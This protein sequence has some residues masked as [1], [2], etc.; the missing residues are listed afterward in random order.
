[1]KSSALVT[2]HDQ[3]S[4]LICM[5]TRVKALFDGVT[6]ILEKENN[7]H[8][9]GI[10]CKSLSDHCIIHGLNGFSVDLWFDK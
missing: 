3:A 10:G 9:A 7:I 5:P 1:M 4:I 6:Y 2:T 8:P